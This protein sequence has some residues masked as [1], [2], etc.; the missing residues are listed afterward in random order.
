MR[1]T[2]IGAMTL[3]FLNLI[4]T[5]VSAMA[6]V[7]FADPAFQTQWNTDEA[8]APGFWGQPITGGLFEPYASA[9][10]GIRL[11][12]YYEKG[13]LETA[14]GEVTNTTLVLD[15]YR[16]RIEVGHFQYDKRPPPATPIAG[17]MDGPNL[18]YATLAA[19]LPE[20]TTGSPK[21]IGMSV[22]T[23]VSPSGIVSSGP[24][25]PA[26]GPES[27]GDYD[28]SHNVLQAFIDYR[29]QFKG[30]DAPFKLGFAITEPFRTTVTAGGMA[31]DV[32]VQAFWQRILIYDPNGPNGAKVTVASTGQAYYAWRY[33]NG[34]MPQPATGPLPI[35]VLS[36][37][38]PGMVTLTA[39]GAAQ[40][41]KNG[42]AAW[43]QTDANGRFTRLSI[44]DTFDFV[45][46]PSDALAVAQ[47]GQLTFMY[48][49]ADPL[50]AIGA[51]FY[52][53]ASAGPPDKFGLVML[54]RGDTGVDAPVMRTG[55]QA[56][57]NANAPPG[58]YIML[59][60][61]LPDGAYSHDC[62]AE[63]QFHVQVQ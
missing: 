30:R 57:I 38:K 8:A 47:G 9:A 5:S 61:I 37:D 29:Q 15:M 62:V 7:T 2:S 35:V 34:A 54:P 51:T 22:A 6:D 12:Q 44:A 13:R 16:G 1:S 31:H 58:D 26:T 4:V 3:L 18:T 24:P 55:S 59:V 25:T 17:D 32:I 11:V 14:S 27:T 36:D 39:G 45:V 63:F 52:P 48:L 10:G 40:T 20:S 46:I 41:G 53:L 43:C 19:V 28:A 56:T 23:R 49:G 42:Y 50:R 60:R 33:A 21:Q